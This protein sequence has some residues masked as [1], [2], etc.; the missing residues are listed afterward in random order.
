MAVEPVVADLIREVLAEELAR[1]KR[2]PREEWV[3]IAD[4][5]DLAAFAMRVLAMGADPG[6]RGAFERGSL[7][8]R[9]DG[10]AGQGRGGGRERSPHVAG[11]PP[12]AARE[13][14]AGRGGGDGIEILDGGLLSERHVARL[15]RG[16]TRLRVGRD[17][18]VTPLARDRLRRMGI[19]I[20][21][22]E[23]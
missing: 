7:V 13:A 4:D 3:R 1:L 12:R 8:F 22:A 2:E 17:A 16:T 6:A 21:R 10:G 14:R 23:S 5:A 15:P 9:L 11:A 19:T 20:E 18:R